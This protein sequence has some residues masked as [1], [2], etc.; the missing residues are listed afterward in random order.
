M[1]EQRIRN[2]RVAGSTPITGSIGI[3]A[4]EV[5]RPCGFVLHKLEGGMKIDLHGMRT[6]DA[7]ELFIA[8]Y[9]RLLSEGGERLEVVH[10]YGSSGVGG[11]I[12]SALMVLMDAYPDKVR[13]ISGEMIG[14]K[15]VTVVIPDELLPSRRTSVGT[16]VRAH[17][18]VKP[19][20]AYSLEEKLSGLANADEIMSGLSGLVAQG[21]AMKIIQDGR[22][23]YKRR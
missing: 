5:V 22:I 14:N 19:V 21:A 12:R 2:A 18:G 3:T 7:I 10:G 1:V 15:G 6:R 13:Y 8:H 16:V 23:L 11:D 20:S 4:A 17:L 9:N